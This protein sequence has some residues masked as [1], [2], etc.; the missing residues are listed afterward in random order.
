MC[1]M[2]EGRKEGRKTTLVPFLF[3]QRHRQKTKFTGADE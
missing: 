3:L 1:E 2:K